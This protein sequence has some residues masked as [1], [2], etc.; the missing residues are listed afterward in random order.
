MDTKSTC[1]QHYSIPE[2]L[3]PSPV[4]HTSSSRDIVQIDSAKSMNCSKDDDDIKTMMDRVPIDS[5]T[6]SK[7]LII[8]IV[9]PNT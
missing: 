6:V 4:T 7:T 2:L 9:I 8:N 3:Y 1:S 5:E